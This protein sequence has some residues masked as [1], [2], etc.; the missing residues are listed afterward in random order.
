MLFDYESYRKIKP[1]LAGKDLQLASV[2]CSLLDQSGGDSDRPLRVLDVGAGDG[3]VLKKVLEL[4]YSTTASKR[5]DVHVDAPEPHP[6][7]IKDFLRG[8]L[9]LKSS[10]VRIEVLQASLERFLSEQRRPLYD[11]ILCSH[12]F[13]HFPQDDWRDLV[14]DLLSLVKPGGR[15]G[16]TLVSRRSWPY[17]QIA[18]LG[19]QS[20]NPLFGLGRLGQ[21]AFV[22]AEDLAPQLVDCWRSVER[23]EVAAPLNFDLWALPG[24]PTA[25]LATVSRLHRHFLEFMLRTTGD[26]LDGPGQL[27]LSE[28]LDSLHRRQPVSFDTVFQLRRN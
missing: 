20:S 9:G 14:E 24:A 18:D 19:E 17:Q 27:I 1:C 5:R 16:I 21:G 12:V 3:R 6:Q 10:E 28:V 23:N 8:P 11:A 15:L 2:Y 26:S 4:H 22:F 7:A 13:Y 25:C